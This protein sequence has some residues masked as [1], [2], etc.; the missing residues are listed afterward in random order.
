MQQVR[1]WLIEC[2]S[3][4][5]LLWKPGILIWGHLQNALTTRLWTWTFTEMAGW[6]PSCSGTSWS[7]SM[8]L[9]SPR[10]PRQFLTVK[11]LF[12]DVVTSSNVTW[13]DQADPHTMCSGSCVLTI[14]GRVQITHCPSFVSCLFRSTNSAGLESLW[15]MTC[16]WVGV[17]V[18]TPQACP[19]LIDWCRNHRLSI[20]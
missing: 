5:V 17:Q 16:T 13:S 9:N 3:P 2:I 15:V 7:Y 10:A 14:Q 12:K 6:M 18:L 4:S 1:H 19:V 20:P 8:A 11:L